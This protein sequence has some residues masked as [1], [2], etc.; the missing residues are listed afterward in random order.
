MQ[1]RSLAVVGDLHYEP[2]GDDEFVSARRQLMAL[3]P[4]TI[5]Q[6]GDLGGYSHCGT[7]Q[8]F[9]EGLSFLSGFQAPYCT[10]IGNHDLES[11]EFATDADAVAAWCDAFSRPQPYTAVDLGP[12]L[13]ICLSS[14]S[15]RDNPGSHHEVRLDA[16]QI[17]W[18]RSVLA[19][20]PEKPTFVFSHAPIAGSGLRVLQNIHLKCPNAWLN[21]T[22]DYAQFIGL[23]ATN[24]QI[25]LW[26]SGHDHLGQQYSDSISQVGNCAFVHTGVIGEVSRDGCRQ[27][28]FIEFNEQGYVLSTVDHVTGRK[29]A[30]LRHDYASGESQRLSRSIAGDESVHFPP[31]PFPT[32]HARLDAA[33]SV[34]TVHRGMVVEFDAALQ[35]PTGVAYDGLDAQRILLQ[36]DNLHVIRTRG[37]VAV[38]RPDAGGHYAQIYTPNPW[39]EQRLSA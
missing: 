3:S 26:F 5:V 34:L 23:V 8:S 6:L 24:P 7:W 10:I 20:N 11:A 19:D 37:D 16:R 36:G 18:F 22:E 31:P 29:R 35:A 32:G 39:H 30:D 38:V 27:S 4:E 21:H 12:A 13:A 17:A 25:K 9:R 2:E 33:A 28:R 15:C 1:N 14:T